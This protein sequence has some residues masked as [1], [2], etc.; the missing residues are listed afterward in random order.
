MTRREGRKDKE[1]EQRTIEEREE[2]REKERSS[3]ESRGEQGRE[4]RKKR[5]EGKRREH[6]LTWTIDLM[7]PDVKRKGKREKK[8]LSQTSKE[9]N[10][11]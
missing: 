11:D 7:K 2:K 10:S 1:R 6:R 8:N 3:E 5:S 9:L 4:K